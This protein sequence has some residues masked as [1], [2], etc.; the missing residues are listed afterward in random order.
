M[1]YIQVSSFHDVSNNEWYS[2]HKMT[3]EA[4]PTMCHPSSCRS[5]VCPDQTAP[6]QCNQRIEGNRPR[7]RQTFASIHHFNII[8]FILT[9]GKNNVVIYMSQNN[10]SLV[11]FFCFSTKK[12]DI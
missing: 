10:L 11:G 3:S 12:V 6:G 4:S 5:Q 9:S 8:R 1:L 7:D 2:N